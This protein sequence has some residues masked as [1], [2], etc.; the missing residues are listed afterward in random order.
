[1]ATGIRDENSIEVKGVSKRYVM[2]DRRE[3]YLKQAFVP[4]IGRALGP[5]GKRLASR[6][7]GRE[8]WALRDI[9]FNVRKGE[10]IG[11]I[12]RNGAG[13]S[14]LL[15]IIAQT[16]NP[17][18][19]TVTVRGRVAALLELGS[20]FNPEFTGLENVFLNGALLGVTKREIDAKLP[21]ILEFAEIGDFVRQ[22]VK[23]YSSGMVLRLAFS[24]YAALEPEVLIVDEAL[25]VGDARFQK[26]CYDHISGLRAR[27]TS[28]L[29]VSHDMG[30]ITQLC[31]SALS[32]NSGEIYECGDPREVVR[33]FHKLMFDVPSKLTSHALTGPVV[34]SNVD[35]VVRN[36]TGQ[37]EE[38]VVASEEIR[39]GSGHARI[40]NVAMFDHN[41]THTQTVSCNKPCT[42][43][44][45]AHFGVSTERPTIFGFI[46]STPKGLE[47]FGT[48]SSTH[49]LSI[50]PTAHG[51]AYRCRICFDVYLSPGKYL[52]TIALAADGDEESFID[53]RFD[54]FAFEVI[55]SSLSFL[56]GITCLP[57]RLEVTQES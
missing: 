26:K 36:G 45:V 8:F 27:G 22:P 38:H 4:A 55:G 56:S 37:P 13:K 34:A 20:G 47:V 35:T 6:S 16:L 23:T 9:S 5:F 44:F 17:T 28:I 33:G 31:D 29:F 19:G 25:S 48:K 43:E 12:G 39:Y 21:Q 32:L 40:G 10:A 14:T 46:I 2:F 1:M 50:P 53:C 52:L 30:A 7:Y 41:R 51:S 18:S 49:S 15:Q 42:I 57:H 54:A 3:D 24:V 11:L